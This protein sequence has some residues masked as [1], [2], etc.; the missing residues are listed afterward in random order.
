[1]ASRSAAH[2]RLVFN[3]R[4]GNTDDHARNHAAFRDGRVPVL[5]P[6]CGC[7]RHHRCAVAGGTDALCDVCD[8]A[9]LGEAERNALWGRQFLNPF[10]LRD[11]G[12]NRRAARRI[13]SSEGTSMWPIRSGHARASRL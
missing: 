9:G 7:A 3:I 8:D 5:T 2:A 6:A 13:A 10:A 11:Y 4:C 1:M 12:E